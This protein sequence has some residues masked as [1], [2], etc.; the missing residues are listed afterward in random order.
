MS[1]TVVPA[2]P[3]VHREVRLASQVEGEL[4]ARHFTIAEVPVPEPRA[5]RCW[6]ATA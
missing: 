1:P 2:I 3:A 6:C 4:T 5:G